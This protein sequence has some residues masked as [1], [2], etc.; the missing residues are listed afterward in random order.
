MSRLACAMR[1]VPT[2]AWPR[3]ALASSLARPVKPPLPGT[4]PASAARVPCASD[5]RMPSA[6]LACSFGSRLACT[7]SFG[8]PGP[9]PSPRGVVE[10]NAPVPGLSGAERVTLCSRVPA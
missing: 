1:D 6:L 5:I 7:V 2:G 9:S 3:I 4:L 8:G 10:G